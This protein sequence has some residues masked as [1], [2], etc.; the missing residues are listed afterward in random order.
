M[1]NVAAYHVLMLRCFHITYLPAPETT[2]LLTYSMD[3]KVVLGFSIPL[4]ERQGILMYNKPS[5]TT[6]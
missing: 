3:L 4:C 2:Y 1:S 5:N 6:K